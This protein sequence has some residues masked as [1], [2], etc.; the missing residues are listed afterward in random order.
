M[1]DL[2]VLR[3]SLTILLLCLQIVLEKKDLL[4]IA[5]DTNEHHFIKLVKHSNVNSYMYIILKE[6]WKKIG[7]Q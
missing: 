4:L 7:N 1:E 3:R 2:T 5:N 6:V